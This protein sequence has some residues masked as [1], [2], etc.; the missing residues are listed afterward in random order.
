MSDRLSYTVLA[1]L[2]VALLGVQI[3][4]KPGFD[5]NRQGVTVIMNSH[6]LS[7]VELV[8]TRAAILANGRLVAVDDLDKLIRVEPDRYTVEVERLEPM[9]DFF[10]LESSSNGRRR[11][12]IPASRLYD[13]MELSRA[14][15]ACLRTCSLKK[16][17]LEESFLALLTPGTNTSV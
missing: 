2:A 9:P 5:L 11:G 1:A 16:A 8:A 6:I 14:T 10:T 3:A 4:I 12:T 17:T 13:L 7:E 15:G